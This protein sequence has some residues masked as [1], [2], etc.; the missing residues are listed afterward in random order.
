MKKTRMIAAFIGVSM[1]ALFAG[2]QAHAE[3]YLRGELAGGF[4]D[5]YDTS[6]PGGNLENS[7]RAGAALGAK[8]SPHVRLEGELAYSKADLEGGGDS[9]ATLGLGNVYYDF[10][11]GTKITPFVGA[12]LGW[13]KFDTSAGDDNGWAYQLTAGLSKNVSDRMTAEVAYHYTAAP[14]LDIGPGS[15]D[16]KS[17]FVGAGLRWKLGG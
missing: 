13:G 5:E 15:A 10:G 2:A 4:S 9:K 8:L 12:G 6:V 14:D 7:W 11:D 16:Y 3:T 17:S 1:A